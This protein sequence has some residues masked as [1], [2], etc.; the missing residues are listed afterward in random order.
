MSDIIKERIEN[1]MKDILYTFYDD[2]HIAVMESF[3]KF[4]DDK[5]S[6]V[7]KQTLIDKMCIDPERNENPLGPALRTL[8]RDAFLEHH[9]EIKSGVTRSEAAINSLSENN[10][11]KYLDYFYGIN[12]KRFL[13]V[14]T[15]KLNRMKKIY[16]ANATRSEKVEWECS[17]CK[18][19]CGFSFELL[20]IYQPK[21]PNCSAVDTLK[22]TRNEEQLSQN[23]KLYKD[24]LKLTERFDNEIKEI[25]KS[26]L[27]VMDKFWHLVKPSIFTKT[28]Y[29][30]L[31]KKHNEKKKEGRGGDSGKKHVGI[32]EDCQIN[33]ASLL[34]VPSTVEVSKIFDPENELK[35]PTANID[36]VD[37]T[38]E[39]A[40]MAIESRL[41]PSGK[42]L[43]KSVIKELTLYVERY[44]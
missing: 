20:D 5:D 39:T 35:V 11:K 3:F 33:I 41:S 23:E 12:Y 28:D 24:F 32:K 8:E 10:R 21:C 22:M 29:D 9:Y 27:V 13:D 37:Y 19:R 42:A 31:M 38:I 44:G 34:N 4:R 2:I 16:S 36:S 15:I 18:H 14:A 17:K 40:V 30:A 7:E 1:L 43:D 6:V 26:D 25:Y